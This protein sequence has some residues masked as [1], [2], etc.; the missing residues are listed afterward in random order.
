MPGWWGLD[1][2]SYG[3]HGDDGKKFQYTVVG[4][5]TFYSETYGQGDVVGCGVDFIKKIIYFTRNGERLRKSSLEPLPYRELT[6]NPRSGCIHRH[7]RQTV[8]LCG[9]W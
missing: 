5:G 6:R 3:Y 1:T 9:V 4:N 8:S 2:Y 7:N